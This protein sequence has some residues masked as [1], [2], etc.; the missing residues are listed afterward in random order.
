MKPNAS[1]L[2][3]SIIIAFGSNRRGLW[4]NPRQEIAKSLQ[5]LRQNGID[6]VALSS[7]YRTRPVGGGRQPEYLNAVGLFKCSCPPGR[8]LRELKRVERDAGRTQLSRHWGPRVLDLDLIGHGGR[9][10]GWP[11]VPGRRRP[12]VLPHPEAHRRRF[13]LQPLLDVAPHWRHPA[14]GVSARRL[15]AGLGRGRQDVVRMRD[16]AP[17]GTAAGPPADAA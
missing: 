2:S 16:Q 17:F 9:V 8:L 3:Q 1:P 6:L 4:G 12:L 10:I 14:L 7:C 13:V 5:V 15:L 11:L